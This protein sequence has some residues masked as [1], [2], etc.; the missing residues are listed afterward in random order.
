MYT[1]IGYHFSHISSFLPSNISPHI[2][3]YLEVQMIHRSMASV[4]SPTSS[5]HQRPPGRRS[6]RQEEWYTGSP[7][8]S[9]GS[10]LHCEQLG[11]RRLH[12][13]VG[14]YSMDPCG[15]CHS[16]WPAW[17]VQQKNKQDSFS[18]VIH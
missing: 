3:T 12:S 18:K 11:S 5:P 2:H 14:S 15:S 13:P 16:F 9:V 7:C 6:P 17:P 1:Y 8:S 4:T 10:W